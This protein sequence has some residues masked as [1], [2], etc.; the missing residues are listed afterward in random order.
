MPYALGGGSP[1]YGGPR[2]DGCL[3]VVVYWLLLV[4]VAC[5]WLLIVDCW[6]LVVSSCWLLVVCC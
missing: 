5:W 3:L 1:A 2:G 6:L 4:V